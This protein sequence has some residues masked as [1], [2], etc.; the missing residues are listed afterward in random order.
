MKIAVCINE[1]SFEWLHERNAIIT[2]LKYFE[3]GKL[4]IIETCQEGYTML[5]LAGKT[6]IPTD[7]QIYGGTLFQTT[8]IEKLLTVEDRYMKPLT[9]KIY[10]ENV[11]GYKVRFP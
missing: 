2:H 11:P 1:H 9:L 7:K 3:T 4:C 5:C 10:Q 8:T 6:A